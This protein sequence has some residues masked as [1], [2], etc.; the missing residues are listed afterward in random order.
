MKKL[1]LGV[2]ATVLLSTYSYGQKKVTLSSTVTEDEYQQMD[3]LDKKLV[4]YIDAGIFALKGLNLNGEQKTKH[5]VTINLDAK[6]GALG[7]NI[8]IAEPEANTPFGSDLP[9]AQSCKICG[10]GSGM[11][12]YKLI[13][14]RLANGPIIV[15]LELISDCIV[16]SWD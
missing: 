11:M 13:K 9:S 5:V 7:N 15:Q 8:V 1:F 12:C 4:D 10:V 6:S 16:I 3:A 14:T 2:I